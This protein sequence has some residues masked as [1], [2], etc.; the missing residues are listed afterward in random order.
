MSIDAI[1]EGVI[2]REGRYSNNPN[3]R[4][5]KTMWGITERVARANGYHGLMNQLPRS[6]AVRIYRKRYIIEPSF[7]QV[8]EIDTRL[9]EELVDTGVNMGPDVPARWLQEWLNA[10]NNQGKLYSD[11]LEDADIGPGT[12][13]A[14]KALIKARGE[15]GIISLLKGLNCSQG[16]RYKDLARGRV[17][18]EAFVFGWLRTRVGL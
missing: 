7:D 10:L 6:E 9:G 5:G 14:L 18:N 2:G 1:I 13:K 8:A 12:I 11:I 15:D 17:R 16:A 3:D 4:G